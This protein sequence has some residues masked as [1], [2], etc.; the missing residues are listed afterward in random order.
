M[1]AVRTSLAPGAR[2]EG[3]GLSRFL[4][5]IFLLRRETD[6]AWP[7]WKK[8]IYYI[9]RALL[10][11]AAG[12]GM[13]VLVLPL[14]VGSFPREVFYGYLESWD[15][16]VLNIAPVA[17]LVLAGYTLLGRAWAGFFLGGLAAFGLSLGNFFKIEFRDDPLLF[18][19]MFNLREAT[20]MADQGHYDLFVNT[21]ML[22]IAG[23]LLAG[24]LLLALLAR[25]RL[26]WKQRLVPLAALVLACAA[27]A[28]Y[29][30]D[31]D[32]Y[33][34]VDNYEH[35]EIWSD[36][37][38]YIAHGFFY[39]FVY[40]IRE[41]VEMPPAGY[42]KSKAEALLSAYQDEDIPAD[43]RVNIIALMREAYADFSRYGIDGLDTSGYELY[44]QLEAESYT[45]DL[46]TNIF[47]GGT[48]DTERCVLTGNYRLHNFRRSVNS[49]AWYLRSQ[50][51]TA[52]GSHPYHQ[53]FYNRQNINSYM[54][55]E[56]YRFMEGDFEKM[57]DTVY[58]EDAYLL[59][60]IYSDFQKNKATGK[61]YFSFSVNVQSHG[62]YA[63]WDMGVE[64]LLAG[65][66]SLECRKA[67]T[68]YLD[69]I[70]K[71]DQELA[72]LMD[73]LR[74]DEEPVVLVTFGD[75]L[76]WMGDNKAFYE[77]MG[78]NLD[79][80]TEEGFFTHYSTRYLI[81]ANDAAKAV[82]GHDM[83][84]EGPSVSPCYLMNVLFRQLG[85]KGPAFTQ[86]MDRM[87]D[88]FPVVSIKGRYVVD[89]VL[90]DKVPADRRALYQ[91]FVYLQQYWR[92]EFLFGDV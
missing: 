6:P 2:R 53:W 44:H 46:V 7:V 28:P 49:Y 21:R 57:T 24:T 66:Y 62:P 29:Y 47:A 67:I 43:R 5:K 80:G 32:R 41:F 52:E 74:E 38:N 55:L 12:V 36:T 70:W 64:E 58:P 50:G 9:W 37:E 35:L 22:L 84:G 27:L 34:A 63:T 8:A 15:T 78:M 69:V 42:S 13:G 91:E 89:G 85:W 59:P 76:P 51:Y 48:V 10:L 86:A 72:K 71:T 14:A 75:H 79:L 20:A 3:D 54:G 33:E 1:H 56:R 17:V 31:V 16:I 87:M 18:E 65:D 19:D 4:D 83:V 60:E 40:S 45:G 90:T 68:N 23:C 82:I 81:W 77:E 92:N 39:P 26:R 25:G 61:P 11:L 30:N 88:V 73:R